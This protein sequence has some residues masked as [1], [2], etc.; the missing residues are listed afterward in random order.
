[1]KLKKQAA[2][3]IAAVTAAVP[4]SANGLL[5]APLSVHAEEETKEVALPNWVPL[6]FAS[7]L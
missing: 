7:A 3:L 5:S 1:M 2:A 4:L 6:D